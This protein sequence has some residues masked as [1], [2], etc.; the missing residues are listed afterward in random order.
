MTE[1]GRSRG[2][3]RRIIFTFGRSR[4]LAEYAQLP[5]FGSQA[6][7]KAELR[8]T[9]NHCIYFIFQKMKHIIELMQICWFY[10]TAGAE[11]MKVEQF[12]DDSALTKNP[13]VSFLHSDKFLGECGTINM[14]FAVY[15]FSH[16]WQLLKC[17]KLCLFNFD[18]C[19]CNLKFQFRV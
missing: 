14:V 19:N 4:I 1:S 5:T 6:E 11:R 3:G 12:F 15:N 8:S 17:L 16:I 18:S 13:I 2:F 9:T 10:C 7:A